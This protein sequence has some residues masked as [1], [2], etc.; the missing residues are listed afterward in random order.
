MLQHKFNFLLCLTGRAYVEK[1]NS[2]IETF[3]LLDNGVY[4]DTIPND[5]VYSRFYTNAT[6]EGR[7]SLKCQ[8]WDE[9]SAYI[10][11]GFIGSAISTSVQ[12]ISAHSR[13]YRRIPTGHFSRVS[14]GGSFKVHIS[15]SGQHF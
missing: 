12:D 5:G 6:L 8:I 9:G 2:E 14:A 1:P 13:R 10:G 11:L 15:N 4:A 7:Y 3:D